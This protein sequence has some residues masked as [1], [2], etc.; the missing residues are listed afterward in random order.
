MS[1]KRYDVTISV[2][3]DFWSPQ[4]VSGLHNAG[5]QVTHHT[6]ARQKTPC[7][8]FIRNIP[9]SALNHLAFRS[10]LPSRLAHSWSR[11]VVDEQGA[12]LAQ[13]SKAFWGWGGCSLKGLK[14]ARD[15]RKSAIL[16]CGST[17]CVWQKNQVEKEYKRLGLRMDELSTDQE[18]AYGMAEYALAHRIC[19]PSRFVFNTF[20]EM[21]ISENKLFLNPYGVDYDFWSKCDRSKRAREPFTFLWVA[22]LMP[23]K[24]IAVLLEAWRKVSIPNARL[25]LVGGASPSIK[26]LLRD[27]PPNVFIKNF[28]DH[29]AIREQMACAHVYVLPSFEEGMARSVLEAAAAGLP[30]LITQET[31]ATDLLQ[32]GKSSLVIP[33]GDVDSLALALKHFSQ[34][35]DMALEMGNHAREAVKFYT[36]NSYGNRAAIFLKKMLHF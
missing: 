19:V 14:K 5:F 17:H 22:A 28:L 15:L 12:F 6:T 8:R 23:R 16:D 20:L 18:L 1:Y 31:G 36:W 26:P 30:A 29:S 27:L 13:K 9:A 25:V 33:S 10:A 2:W 34:N 7:A 11:R 3:N 21:G 24:G 4:L 35:P 32:D